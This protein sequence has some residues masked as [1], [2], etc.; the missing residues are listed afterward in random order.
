MAQRIAIY[1]RVMAETGDEA[2]AM[3][4]SA[5][6]IN[7]LR[8]GSGQ[9]AQALVKTVPFLGAYAQS[10]DVLYSA[11]VGGGLKGLDS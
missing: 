7:F 10:I 2:L 4:Q 11:L 5:N 1:N 9:V 8:H 6:V 3:Y